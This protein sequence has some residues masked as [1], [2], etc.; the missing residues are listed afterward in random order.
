M[1]YVQSGGLGNTMNQFS[2]NFLKV[3]TLCVASTLL[4]TINTKTADASN[5]IGDIPVAGVS[6]TI[7]RYNEACDIV[8][9]YDI[10]IA[11][12]DKGAADNEYSNFGISNVSDYLNIRKE[13]GETKTVIGKL[14]KN[15]SCNI[16]E[17]TDNGWA[18]IKSGKVTGYV[19]AEYL[20]TGNDAVALA[21]KVGSLVATVTTTTLNV[22]EEP[23]LLGNVVTSVPI[24]EELEVVELTSDWVKIKIDNDEGYV[25]RQYVKLSYEFSKAVTFEEGDIVGISGTRNRLVSFAK[26]YL[27]GRYV[28]G[29]TTLGKGVDCSGF[30]QQVYKNFGISIPRTSG[31]QAS[32][33]TTISASSVKP[34]D[35]VFYGN[36]RGSINH[37]A[38][39]IGNGQVIHAS[40]ARTGI[41]ISNMYYRT[42]AKAVRY[43]SD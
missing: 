24:D 12:L 25:S 18:K 9:A 31:A 8:A 22:R 27:G 38:I 35:L 10:A 19:K 30:T 20:V 23:S 29:G 7:D 11:A 13:P 3:S 43:I 32:S 14:P 39:Y 42:P 37:V 36:G 17:Y 6:Y 41:K 28:W 2:K 26:K 21:K 4:I 16:I 5:V 1:K 33:G 34:G 15:A 40:N